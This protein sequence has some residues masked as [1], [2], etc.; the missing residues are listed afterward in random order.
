M[1]YKRGFIIL[2]FFSAFAILTMDTAYSGEYS[3]D[4]SM[5][6][7]LGFYIDFVF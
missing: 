6:F 5:Q 2:I 3:E 1:N 7:A 4:S